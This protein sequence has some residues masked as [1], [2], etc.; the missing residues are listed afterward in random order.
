VRP[1]KGVA[2]SA[3]NAESGCLVN[4]NLSAWRRHPTRQDIVLDHD[5]QMY[6]FDV[7]FHV[8]SSFVMRGLSEDSYWGKAF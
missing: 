8:L 5:D 4:T 1:A 7:V 2:V 3:E 6:Y